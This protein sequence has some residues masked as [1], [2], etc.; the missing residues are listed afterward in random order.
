LRELSQLSDVLEHVYEYRKLLARRDMLRRKLDAESRDRLD[1]LERLFAAAP[2]EGGEHRRRYARCEL[3]IR[4]TVKAGGR[5][6][7]VDIVNVGGGGMCVTPA[8]QLR[9]GERAVVRVISRET[10]RE[11]HYPVQAL[12]VQRTDRDS[13]MGLPFVGAPLQVTRP[14]P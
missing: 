5:V 4:A 8:P 9:P 2:D 1:V 3:S 7:A 13:S 6:Q 10:G 14:V 11:Y 12:W